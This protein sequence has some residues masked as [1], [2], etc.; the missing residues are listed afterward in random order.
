MSRYVKNHLI[1]VAVKH[2]YFLMGLEA[3]KTE[4]ENG[5]VV[6]KIKYCK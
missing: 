4:N 5:L 6:E 1:I 2:F 3:R